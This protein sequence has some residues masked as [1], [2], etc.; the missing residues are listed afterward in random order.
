M[1]WELLVPSK[2]SASGV[3]S[4]LTWK[5]GTV[6]RSW[7]SISLAEG[8]QGAGHHSTSRSDFPSLDSWLDMTIMDLVGQVKEKIVRKIVGGV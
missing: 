5:L 1:K 2:G 3:G 6:S 7:G 4:W 8:P